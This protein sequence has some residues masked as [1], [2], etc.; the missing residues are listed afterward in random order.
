MAKFGIALGSGPRGLGFESRHSDHVGASSISL[1]P[2][3]FISQSALMPLLLLS[4]SN[5]LRWASICFFA[6][7]ERSPLGTPAP[8]R[9]DRICA[10]GKKMNKK[11]ELSDV[12][13]PDSSLLLQ[14]FKVFLHIFDFP[15][16]KQTPRLASQRKTSR[17]FLLYSIFV[18][19]QSSFTRWINPLFSSSSG[20][21]AVQMI[22]PFSSRAV[23]LNPRRSA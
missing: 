23:I 9:E 5:P 8:N 7:T 4:K 14:R 6:K 1:A 12:Q 21:D 15:T 2:T 13:K 3:F 20:I 17:G 22:S 19:S 11:K 18:I 10:S 16:Y